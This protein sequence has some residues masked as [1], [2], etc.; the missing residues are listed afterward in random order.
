MQTVQRQL[1]P[2][3]AFWT[4]VLIAMLCALYMILASGQSAS[5][6]SKQNGGQSYESAGRN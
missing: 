6:E 3:F 1:M 2:H 4:I 5:Q